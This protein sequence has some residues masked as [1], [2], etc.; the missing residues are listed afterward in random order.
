MNATSQQGYGGGG[1]LPQYDDR[2]HGRPAYDE[3]PPGPPPGR[4]PYNDQHSSQHG[5]GNFQQ[6][7][8]NVNPPPQDDVCPE[9]MPPGP[10]S[11][12]VAIPDNNGRGFLPAYASVLERAGIDKP[13]FLT[14]IEDYN[15]M[16]SAMQVLTLRTEMSPDITTM[17]VATV[18]KH[19]YVLSTP[20][21]FFFF[22]FFFYIILC[23]T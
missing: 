7:R 1:G 4:G 9:A 17:C 5:G 23:S 10:L 19:R 16:T 15:A 11:L 6:D 8:R 12:P 18:L 2:Q 21:D 22:F 20:F 14:F 3:P 13:T